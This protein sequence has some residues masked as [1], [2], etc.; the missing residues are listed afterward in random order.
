M[1]LMYCDSFDNYDSFPGGKWSSGV[2]GF[3]PGARTGIQAFIPQP[4]GFAGV[5]RINFSNRITMIVGVAIKLVG[6]TE[7]SLFSFYN[8]AGNVGY[9]GLGA[10]SDGSIRLKD[11]TGA[12]VASSPPGIV[13]EGE[14][15]YVEE[16]ITMTA[17]G[18]VVVRVNGQTVI[19]YVGFTPQ[20]PYDG[21][22]GFLLEGE[23]IFDVFCDDFYLCDDSGT[24]NNDFLGPVRIYAVTPDAN[25][26]PLDFTPLSGTN[27]SEVNQVPPPGDAAYV[28]AALPGNIDQYHYTPTGPPGVFVIKGVQHSFSCRL[29]EPGAH[30][31]AS[32][33]N[34]NTG[35]NPTVGSNAPDTDYAFV[36]TPYDVNPNT[37]LPFQVGD[38]ATTWFGPNITS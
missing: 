18:T 37:G 30:T 8:S 31:M 11:Y 24:V 29:D 35:P 25:E 16:K 26:T 4:E 1:S 33:V 14:Y 13:S 22:D 36:I 34:A 5:P 3:N 21:A 6:G 32:Q 27:F 12:V 7:G 2:G 20:A 19:T 17:G 38:F 23:L 28:S 9:G 10:Y 15:F